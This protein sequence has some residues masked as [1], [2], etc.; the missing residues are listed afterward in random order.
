MVRQVFRAVVRNM[1]GLFVGMLRALAFSP[2]CYVLAPLALRKRG[3][4]DESCTA[5]RPVIR[6]FGVSLY[7]ENVSA[8]PCARR[9]AFTP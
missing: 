7:P 4:A 1:A 8:W 3:K 5:F 9:P 6:W 2:G